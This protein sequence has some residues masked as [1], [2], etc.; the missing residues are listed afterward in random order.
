MPRSSQHAK[1]N[2]ILELIECYEKLNKVG[3]YHIWGM[4]GGLFMKLQK[5]Y[6]DAPLFFFDSSEA[7]EES[8]VLINHLEGIGI[9]IGDRMK[10]LSTYD[11]HSQAAVEYL[12]TNAI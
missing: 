8:G 3:L 7:L 1:S 9:R 12:V 6:E 5:E 4:G 2:G 11:D 10:V